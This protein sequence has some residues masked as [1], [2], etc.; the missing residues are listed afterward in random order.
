MCGVKQ[1]NK[2]ICLTEIRRVWGILIGKFIS[3]NGDAWSLGFSHVQ[4]EM[5]Q[6]FSKKVN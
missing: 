6:N 2:R 5:I 4:W 3:T 1:R